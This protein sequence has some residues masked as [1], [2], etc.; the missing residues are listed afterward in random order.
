VEFFREIRGKPW[1]ESEDAIN[2]AQLGGSIAMPPVR[3]ALRIFVAVV[4]V[5]FSLSVVAYS[6][7]MLLADWKP[8]PEPTIMWLN[9]IVLIA[10]SVAMQ[11]AVVGAR[12]DR[13][14]QLEA[15]LLIGGACSLAFLA[16]QL[17]VVRQLDAL[18]YFAPTNPALSFLYMLTAMH[19]IH[20]LGGLFV[21]ARTVFRLWRGV[22]V[23]KVLMTTELCAF[24]WHFLLALWLVLFV[25]FVIT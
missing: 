7:R 12:R 17:L 16:G 1:L 24:Y 25:W 15:G 18:G 3:L 2:N 11:W 19:A 10:S 22:E 4:G 13:S 6:D 20:I 5:V 14:S 21:W 9:L 23:E 8:V